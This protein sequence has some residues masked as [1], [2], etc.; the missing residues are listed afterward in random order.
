M[1]KIGMPPSTVS[2][3]T[4]RR[5]DEQPSRRADEQTSSRR[6]ADEQQTSQEGLER[7]CDNNNVKIKI[8]ESDWAAW[9]LFT[10]TARCLITSQQKACGPC[11]SSWKVLHEAWTAHLF[12][13]TQSP[14][15]TAMVWVES[16][17]VLFLKPAE[18]VPDGLPKD[19][20]S[21]VEMTWPAGQPMFAALFSAVSTQV[22]A[23]PG[24]GGGGPC[25]CGGLGPGCGFEAM[26]LI[27]TTWTGGSTSIAGC[28]FDV[29]CDVS[30]GVIPD[31]TA[32]AQLAS[33]LN[34]AAIQPTGSFRASMYS[35]NPVPAELPASPGTQSQHTSS[36]KTTRVVC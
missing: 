3:Q 20:K 35:M 31:A 5:A 12:L 18:Q 15:T 28:I 23:G 21:M 10:L 30:C 27:V 6:A 1:L 26:A 24:G 29:S 2:L 36:Y 7:K 14:L 13:P 4:S 19:A 33:G 34:P 9:S 16:H 8:F 17:L 22:A 11:S 25:G 32:G